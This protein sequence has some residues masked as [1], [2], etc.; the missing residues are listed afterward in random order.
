MLHAFA[1][2]C[3]SFVLAL[4]Y[5]FVDV[6]YLRPIS[7]DYPFTRQIF[8]Q[9]CR[10]GFNICAH[11]ISRWWPTDTELIAIKSL[12]SLRALGFHHHVIDSSD[13]ACPM[14]CGLG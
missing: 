6:H 12:G 7:A 5:P 14:G 4:A 9:A 8:S 13:G 1:W 11:Q 2:G 10:V 3:P